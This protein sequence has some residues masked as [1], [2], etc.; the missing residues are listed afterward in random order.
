MRSSTVG[1]D[2]HMV[3]SS[4]CWLHYCSSTVSV[5]ARAWN[6]K[7]LWWE[8][9]KK[10]NNNKNL[11]QHKENG[12]SNKMV[13]SSLFHNTVLSLNSAQNKWLK[14]Q[15]MLLQISWK[16]FKKKKVMFGKWI[17]FYAS[18]CQVLKHSWPNEDW[19]AVLGSLQDHWTQV[20]DKLNSGHFSLLSSPL[21]PP[22]CTTV[23]QC[24]EQWYEHLDNVWSS[25]AINY[26]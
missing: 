11:S 14:S 12:L 4:L 17:V 8:G 22:P 2:A 1:N 15:L 24:L 23:E 19:R 20:M 18:V 5:S 16:G 6:Q 7:I 3:V 21:P 25:Q 10:Q 13:A 26:G 9:E